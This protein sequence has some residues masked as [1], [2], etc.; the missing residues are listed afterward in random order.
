MPLEWSSQ[1]PSLGNLRVPTQIVNSV[2]CCFTPLLQTGSEDTVLVVQ[3]LDLI[4]ICV[5]RLRKVSRT[6]A[7]TV[8]QFAGLDYEIGEKRV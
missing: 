8:Y 7:H 1:C 5:C 2:Q 6:S 4:K 3:S